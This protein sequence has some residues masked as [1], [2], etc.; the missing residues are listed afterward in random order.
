MSGQIYIRCR[1]NCQDNVC[2]ICIEGW[3][4]IVELGY[5]KLGDG[6]YIVV[7]VNRYILYKTKQITCK[8][9][10]ALDGASPVAYML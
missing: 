5:V 3:I 10:L 6:E 7:F 2:L 9:V 4:N 8:V 1:L